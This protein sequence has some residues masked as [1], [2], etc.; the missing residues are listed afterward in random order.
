[1]QFS[2]QKHENLNWI[3][4]TFPWLGRMFIKD[5]FLILLVLINYLYFS[6]LTAQHRNRHITNICAIA[7]IIKIKPQIVG[8]K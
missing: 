6:I 5:D 7:I 4:Y 2:E 3:K 8:Q 1:M